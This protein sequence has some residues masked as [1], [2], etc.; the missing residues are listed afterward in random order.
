VRISAAALLATTL[1]A[2]MV[3]PRYE[4][5]SAVPAGTRL[6]VDAMR[7]STRI[8][9]DSLAAA[10][11]RDSTSAAAMFGGSP[12][13]VDS[14]AG[15]AWLDIVHDTTLVH[16]VETAIR[17]SPS[18]QIAVA[19]IREF[20]ADL[21][22][23][24][25]PLFP[26]A[27]V[28]GSQS[29]NQVAFAAFP[30][31]GFRATR[32]TADVTWELDFWGRLRSG[33]NAANADLGAQEAAQRATVLSL[34]SDVASGYLQLLELDQEHDIAE[35]TLATRQATLGLARER[36]RQG[37]ISELDVRQFEAQ[38]AAPAVTLAQAERLRSQTEHSLS[39]LLGQAPIRIPRGAGL[40]QAVGALVVPDSIPASLLARRPDVQ[41]AER[42][43]AAAMAR[44]GIADAARLPTIMITGSYGSQA[45]RVNDV[46]KSQTEVYQLQAGVSIPLFNAGRLSGAATAAR[47]RAEQS[48][49]LYQQVALN[50][51]RDANDAL[52]AVRTA[53]DQAAAEATQAEALRQALALAQLRYQAGLASYLDLLDAQRSLFSAE[54]ALSQAQL[55]Q[56][57]SAVLLYKAL[58]GS[59]RP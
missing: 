32:V 51:M 59:W 20:R 28:N 27:T 1:G 15:V 50:A 37:V 35:R 40:A 49:A 8:F 14:A 41:Q 44:I 25:A 34:V 21:G 4:P 52:V 26:A 29:T 47:A 53:R 46:F 19:R 58:G 31:T 57:T 24:R 33:A 6:R 13:T 11:R 9:F 7:D 39:A 55:Q 56:L 43:Y 10:R 23:A 30:P 18:I 5:A 36:F 22:I 45:S 3:G 16:L 2:C 42:E 48:R 12:L 17:Q 38:V 54:L